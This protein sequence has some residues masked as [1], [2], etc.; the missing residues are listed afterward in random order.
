MA[1]KRRLTVLKSDGAPQ[2]E[3]R[4][5]WQWVGFGVLMVFTAW[6]PLAYVAEL[7]KTRVAPSVAG[8]LAFAT[9]PLGAGAF[10]GGFLVGR[11]GKPAGAR[12]ALV[13][14]LAAASIA[15]AVASAA[16]GFVATSL[17]VAPLGA[18]FAWTGGAYG[19]KKRGP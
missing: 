7:V 12:E 2:E 6:L 5:P 10:A 9:V 18:L 8:A 16:G 15:I 13:A 11:F 3:P 4:P 1:E 14:G 17:L 19:V